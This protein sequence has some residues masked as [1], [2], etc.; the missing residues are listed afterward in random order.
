MRDNLIVFERRF[1]KNKSAAN[2]FALIQAYWLCFKISSAEEYLQKAREVTAIML[3]VHFTDIRL[4]FMGILMG[5]EA[6]DFSWAKKSLSV[7]KRYK[8]HFK[9]N[10]PIFFAV[11]TFLLCLLNIRAGKLR[12]FEKQYM[13]LTELG[14]F[15]YRNDIE[16]SAFINMLTGAA[17]YEY[18][19]FDTAV[20]KLNISYEHGNISCFLYIYALDCVYT[21][22]SGLDISI[23][24][25]LFF[26]LIRWALNK[27]IDVSNLVLRYKDVLISN[28][29][30]YPDLAKDIYK[31]CPIDE[32]LGWICLVL[33]ENL[34]YS[35]EAL[36]FYEQAEQK[37]LKLPNLQYMFIKTAFYH[38]FENIGRTTLEY[39]LKSGPLDRELLPFVCHLA[40]TRHPE[41]ISPNKNRLIA[42]AQEFLAGSGRGRYFNSI[43]K[44]FIKEAPLKND[45][46]L[47]LRAEKI[48]FEDLFKFKITVDNDNVKYIIV[49]RKEFKESAR[50]TLS[51]K[52]K[53]I[54]AYPGFMCR[55]SDSESI[56]EVPYECVAMV[57]NSDVE[58][59][60]R[61]FQKGMVSPELLIALS[62]HYMQLEVLPAE[63]LAVFKSAL[64]R[65]EISE[66]FKMRVSA[67]AGGY[68]AAQGDFPRAAAY[69]KSVD[70][71]TFGQEY[72]E[73]MLMSFI[74]SDNFEKAAD[75]IVKKAEYVSDRNMFYCL[76]RI[77]EE[78]TYNS[79]IAPLAYKMLL[80]SWYDKILFSVVFEH[81]NGSQKEW[82][83]LSAALSRIGIEDRGLNEIILKNSIITHMF[84]VGAQMIFARMYETDAYN[85]ITLDYSEYCAY[86]II[87]NSKRPVYEAI[88]TLEMISLG[89]SE[90]DDIDSHFI[91]YALTHLYLKL[92]LRTLNAEKVMKKAVDFCEQD[93]FI[94]PIFKQIK[95]K[96][97]MSA[98]IEKNQPFMY[99]GLPGKTVRLYYKTSDG[100]YLRKTMKYT[101]FGLYFVNVPHFYG[102]KISYYFSEETNT[103]SVSTKEE[104]IDNNLAVLSENEGAFFMINNAIVYKSVYK[105]DLAER[106]I[107]EYL[108]KEEPVVRSTIL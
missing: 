4:Y 78:K 103:G 53:V 88:N 108:K 47:M 33:M 28:C 89:N 31:I 17:A 2:T 23:S 98:Y 73:H 93:E 13:K 51:G 60:K 27:R 58:L 19:D 76:K 56:I 29:G 24:K 79:F 86:E 9:H 11:Y 52:S 45:D 18:G 6:G 81:Y 39:L 91:A 40:V 55:F 25:E 105:Y 35:H 3:E 10:E 107:A 104:F 90:N 80:K 75:V 87:M 102:D 69:Y 95:D 5:I 67:A 94:F 92:G 96:R 64:V 34:D 30:E 7:L 62:S 44:F 50:Y 36:Y 37:R 106:T 57:E 100:E 83:E 77:A 14:M 22:P 32:L 61:F 1:D 43:Y 97:L 38:G 12:A 101:K 49:L 85:S 15:D 74:N 70:M 99:K 82:L 46:A 84:D 72:A 48:V 42:F 16:G 8:N 41:I 66:L 71:N 26:G 21:M 68:Y 59:Y 54:T 63:C 20:K 65:P